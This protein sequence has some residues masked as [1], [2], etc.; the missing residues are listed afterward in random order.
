MAAVLL[1]AALLAGSTAMAATQGTDTDPL[2]IATDRGLVR[3]APGPAVREFK[4]IPFARPPLGEL[5]FAPPQPAAP[6]RGVLDATRDRSACPQLARYGVTDASDDEDCLY[7]NVTVP[8]PNGAPT[9]K[10]PVM[11]WIHGGAYV[12]GSS[13]IYPLDYLSRTGDMI[14]VSINYRLGVLGFMTHPAFAAAHNGSLGLEDQ[15]QALRWVK[16]NIAAFGGD[17]A[18]VT[19][20]GESAGAGSV[21]MQLIAAK[22][23][24][25]LFQKAIVQSLGCT[26][27][28]N[29]MAEAGR[30]GDEVSRQLHCTDAASAIA[31]LRSKSVQ[32]L[33]DAQKSVGAKYPRAFTPSVGSISVPRQG[34]EAFSN[35]RFLRVPIINGGNRDEMRLYVAYAIQGGQVVTNDTYPKLLTSLYGDVAPAVLAKYPLGKFSS[36][37]AALGTAESDFVPDGPLSNCL[38]LKMAVDA[39]RYVPVYEYEFADRRAP[40]EMDDPGFEMGAVHSAEL[41][42]FFPHISYNSKINGAGLDPASQPVSTAM[43]A[44]WSSFVHTGHPSPAG[45]PTWP[46]YRAATDV[47]RFEPGAMHTFDAAASHH[48]EFWQEHYPAQ[49]GGR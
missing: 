18:N 41:P 39:S 8:T 7:L 45:L 2:T 16:R 26:V 6:W 3:G 22:E 19:L 1:A 10:R 25:G 37:P 17:A 31:C 49:L 36:A 34:A 11:V 5:R 23:T 21:C 4:G 13:N 43:V 14:V 42:Y 48:C 33:L 27:R 44:Y 30:A 12:G 9:T 24:R 15:R 29:S 32:E 40:P 46:R 35:G 28:L 20:A 47:M 38:Y